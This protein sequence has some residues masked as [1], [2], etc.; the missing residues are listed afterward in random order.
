ML[1]GWMLA[2]LWLYTKATDEAAHERRA[3]I[4]LAGIILGFALLTKFAFGLICL[5]FIVLLH[6]PTRYWKSLAIYV[7]AAAIVSAPWYLWMAATRPGFGVHAQLLA[8]SSVY[9]AGTHHWYFYFNQSL[10]NLPL[11]FPIFFLTFQRGVNSEWKGRWWLATGV[12]LGSAVLLLAVMKTK[13]PHFGLL[14]LPPLAVWIALGAERAREARTPALIFATA[15]PAMLWGSGQQVRSLL[16][17]GIGWR[18]AVLPSWPTV[19]V[20]LLVIGV[21]IFTLIRSEGKRASTEHRLLLL[22]A[23]FL[24]IQVARIVERSPTAGEGGAKATV[25]AL[26]NTSG[27]NVLVLTDG[28][29]HSELI[30]QLSYYSNGAAQG[31][32]DGRPWDVKPVGMAPTQLQEMLSDTGLRVIVE[33]PIDRLARRSIQDSVSLSRAEAI[34]SNSGLTRFSSKSYDLYYHP[35]R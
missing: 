9:E 17:G 5:P 20:L 13:M 24:C 11:L 35:V 2:S 29:A 19:I 18:N 33:R 1:C 28:S 10:W 16:V 12:W 15:L 4:V 23:M 7:A 3:Q 32:M 25:R 21:L 34:L 27:S 14:L 6:P 30:P 31:W 26:E 8:T 22:A